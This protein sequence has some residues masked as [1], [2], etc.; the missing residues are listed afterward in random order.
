MLCGVVRSNGETGQIHIT[1]K[2]DFSEQM[3]RVTAV[4]GR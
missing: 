4:E 3:I 2:T 1:A